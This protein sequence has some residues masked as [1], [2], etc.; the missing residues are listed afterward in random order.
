MDRKNLKSKVTP[1]QVENSKRAKNIIANIGTMDAMN[2]AV[3]ATESGK[4]RPLEFNI[5]EQPIG[6][7]SV[8]FSTYI[9]VIVREIVPI[10]ILTWHK[11]KPD[12]KDR[13]WVMVK[14]KFIVPKEARKLTLM[15]MGK[16]WREFKVEKRKLIDINDEYEQALDKCSEVVPYNQWENKEIADDATSVVKKIRWSAVWT[17]AHKRK[18]GEA[19]NELVQEKMDKIDEINSNN[20]DV[21]DHDFTEVL[22]PEYPRHMRVMGFGISPT[23]YKGIKH[24]GV[25]VQCLQEEVRVLWEELVVYEEVNE[26]V[27]SLEAQMTKMTKLLSNQGNAQDEITPP[28]SSVFL[29]ESEKESRLLVETLRSK[30]PINKK[31]GSAKS[32]TSRK[33]QSKA[34][35]SVEHEDVEPSEM[36]LDEIESRLGSLLQA[37]TISQLKSGVWKEWLEAIALL[38]QEVEGLQDLDQSAE[39]LICLLCVVPGWGEGALYGVDVNTGITDS[40]ANFVWEPTVV[41]INALNVTIE[42]ACLVLGVDE[43]VKSL[44]VYKLIQTSRNAQR[45]PKALS[46]LAVKHPRPFFMVVLLVFL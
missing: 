24:S 13:L 43:M 2:P 12:I 1:I 27:S 22:G 34:T 46:I 15:S 5:K 4:R 45:H 36:S 8:F 25:I 20:P 31:S 16:D 3:I 37:N 32:G 38:K 6:E 7:N 23:L 41:K 29:S 39:L 33:G 18:N 17:R 26:K 44:K 30:L 28:E 42:V 9:G 10:T 11:V 14:Q 35:G 40:F 19:V 21:G